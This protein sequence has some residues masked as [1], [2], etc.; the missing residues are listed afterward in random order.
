MTATNLDFAPVRL[1]MKHLPERQ[2][3]ELWHEVVGRQMLRIDSEPLRDSD[4]AFDA[5]ITLR[6]MPGLRMA[7][8]SLGGS[9]DRRTRELTHDGNDDVVL[10]LNRAGPLQAA[11]RGHEAVAGPGE[12]VILTCCEPANFRRPLPGRV[13]A[14]QISR[15]ALAPLV[16]NLDD[17]AGRFIHPK[18]AAL[19]LLARYVESL[20][21]IDAPM[22]PELRR[23]VFSHICDL[24][25]TA[26]GANRDAAATAQDRGVA[27]A[28]LRAIKDD[29]IR[30]AGKQELTIESVATRH[31]LA[32]RQVQR[33]FERDG[34]TF[35]RFLLSERLARARRM[36]VNSHDPVI[37]ISDVAFACG[38]GDLAYFNRAFRSRYGGTPSDI[39]MQA[40]K[41]AGACE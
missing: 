9:R 2:R 27:E 4:V 37:R 20:D 3:V 14:L 6:A 38:F 32:V 24:V 34:T 18:S 39:R 26:I 10:L 35:T 25:A 41:P 1:A 13:L 30:N 33:L 7:T 8:G 19:Q 17:A 31:G 22:T 28:K 23:A 16:D 5:D 15:A 11:Q 21:E 40:C 12:G 29:V 36:L